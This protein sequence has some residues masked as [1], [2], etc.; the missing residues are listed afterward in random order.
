MIFSLCGLAKNRAFSFFWR[1][2]TND[3]PPAICGDRPQGCLPREEGAA[4]QTLAPAGC[5]DGT[6]VDGAED[7]AGEGGAG[8]WALRCP[9][10]AAPSAPTL[11]H[12]A[13][14]RR[15]SIGVERPSVRDELAGAVEV[16]W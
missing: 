6:E 9:T 7:D 15:C 16:R 1:R 10:P 2:E 3:P 14:G 13:S 8:R 5:G 12:H 4:A 11:H